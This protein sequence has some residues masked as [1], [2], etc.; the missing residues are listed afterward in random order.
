[1]FEDLHRV[2]CFGADSICYLLQGDYMGGFPKLGGPF[3]ASLS[4]GFWHLGVYIGVPL[5]RETTIGGPSTR[6]L[7]HLQGLEGY[8]RGKD[9]WGLGSVSKRS[10]TRENGESTNMKSELEVYEVCRVRTAVT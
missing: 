10:N 3:W 5:F 6:T 4:E 9:V 8:K 2:C 1:M 7:S